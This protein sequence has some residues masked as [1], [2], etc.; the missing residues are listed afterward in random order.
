MMLRYPF[1][2]RFTLLIIAGIAVLAT[3]IRLQ[4]IVHDIEKH[5]RLKAEQWAL[6]VKDVSTIQDDRDS[7]K[8]MQVQVWAKRIQNI[9][10]IESERDALEVALKASN[11]LSAMATA[12]SY[13]LI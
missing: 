4:F 6:H 11:S 9:A 12:F 10:A 3:L 1:S 7:T 2:L 8:V 5:E 13:S